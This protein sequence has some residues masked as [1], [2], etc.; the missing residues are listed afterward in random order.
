M[1]KLALYN[2]NLRPRHARLIR[3]NARYTQD[4]GRYQNV[5]YDASLTAKLDQARRADEIL[6]CIGRDYPA[7]GQRGGAYKVS[8][9]MVNAYSIGNAELPTLYANREATESN[10][11]VET[12]DK[13]V[14][15]ASHSQPFE[16]ARIQH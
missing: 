11:S 13:G 10:A 15:Y 1:A 6:S 16:P 2:A 9:D 5:V 3:C 14:D 4:F 7:N 12:L 8:G